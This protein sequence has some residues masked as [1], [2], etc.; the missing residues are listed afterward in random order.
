[1]ME[2][3]SINSEKQITKAKGQKPGDSSEIARDTLCYIQT[4]RNGKPSA[5]E[6]TQAS[7]EQQNTTWGIV[8]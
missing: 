6:T 5:L 8:S 1:M 4:R 3:T 2:G 7:G